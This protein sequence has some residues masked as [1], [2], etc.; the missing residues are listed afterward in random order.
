MPSATAGALT[1]THSPVPLL[2]TV[3]LSKIKM[4]RGRW[5]TRGKFKEAFLRKCLKA[6]GSVTGNPSEIYQQG[7][8]DLEKCWTKKKGYFG[9]ISIKGYRISQ[10][11]SALGLFILDGRS[12]Q[13]NSSVNLVLSVL[14]ATVLDP[15][16]SQ[17]QQQRTFYPSAY[18]P[19]QLQLCTLLFLFLA[20]C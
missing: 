19:V 9:E 17:D 13:W 5:L 4:N 20:L 2:H 8:S 10:K 6:D 11:A 12:R 16:Q 3:T 15:E 7:D 18:Q 14:S 1:Q